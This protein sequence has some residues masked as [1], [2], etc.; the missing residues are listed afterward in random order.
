MM[1]ICSIFH[2]LLQTLLF[3]YWVCFK[4]V[5]YNVDV[6]VGVISSVWSWI[7]N[8]LLYSNNS[9]VNIFL[10]H[11]WQTYLL[12]ICDVRTLILTF[13]LEELVTVDSFDVY[14]FAFEL[15][16]YSSC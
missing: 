1:E 9:C 13:I 15:F 11:L 12:V 16:P 5:I 7:V 10:V 6:M 4:R 14:L 8:L 3:D 2:V